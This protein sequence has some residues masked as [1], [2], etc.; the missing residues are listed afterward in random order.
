MSDVITQTHKIKK[1]N[2]LFFVAVLM[3]SSFYIDWSS[4]WNAASRMALPLSLALERRWEIDSY[5]DFTGDKATINGHYYS[6][7]GPLPGLLLTPVLYVINAV[8]PLADLPVADRLRFSLVLGSWLIG[9]LSFTLIVFWAFKQEWIRNSWGI[10]LTMLYFFGSFLF[11]FS[12]SFFSHALAGML[13]FLSFLKLHEK[14]ELLSGVLIGMCFMTEYSTAIFGMVW[15]LY[16][17][18][19][20]NWRGVLWLS[21]GIMPFI[22]L[23]GWYNAEITG[24]PFDFAYKYQENFA[25]NSEAYGFSY[26]SLKALF[27]ITLSPYRGLLFYTPVLLVLIFRFKKQVLNFKALEGAAFWA[28]MLYIFFFSMNK[29]WYMGWTFGPRYLYP[30]AILLFFLIDA[31]KPWKLWE[32]VGLILLGAF[33]LFQ[34][35]LDKATFLYPPTEDY[36]PINGTL[37]PKALEGKW[38]GKHL[39]SFMGVEGV[40]PHILFALLLLIAMLLMVSMHR[41]F[42]FWNQKKWQN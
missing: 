11:V 27:H 39:M 20:K 34:T 15:G 38:N 41:G 35:L 12:G 6:D 17:L 32:K 40:W 3:L 21:I 16:L 29:S 26:P 42:L 2:Q 28:C 4:N 31:T 10:P 13:I 19:N 37:I 36:F 14:K 5:A 24:S 30:V 22:I 9:S 25:M 33:G 18:V 1:F 7:K 23:Q 8:Y